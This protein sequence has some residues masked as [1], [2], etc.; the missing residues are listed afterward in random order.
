MTSQIEAAVLCQN[1]NM[2]A[3]KTVMLAK[4]K[5]FVWSAGSFEEKGATGHPKN[6]STPSAAQTPKAVLLHRI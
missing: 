4:I 3:G 5:V 2:H 1:A 6:G